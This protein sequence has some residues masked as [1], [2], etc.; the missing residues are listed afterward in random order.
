MSPLESPSRSAPVWHS[1]S[2]FIA[3]FHLSQKLEFEIL[4]QIELNHKPYTYD[5]Y[6]YFLLNDSHFHV[7]YATFE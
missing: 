1:N 3:I 6:S 2:T 4:F 7:K 5:V